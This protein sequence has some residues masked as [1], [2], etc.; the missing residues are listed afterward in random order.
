MD[1]LDL[2]K[3]FT[4]DEMVKQA[5]AQNEHLKAKKDKEESDKR[6]AESVAKLNANR[7]QIL[8]NQ[9]E[10]EEEIKKQD[11]FEKIKAMLG[12]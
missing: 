11:K 8:R 7:D 5:G 6:V 1:W 9:A 4:S 2:L 10:A 12:K 3:Q